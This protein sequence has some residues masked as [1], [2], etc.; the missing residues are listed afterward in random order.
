MNNQNQDNQ[1]Y[2]GSPNYANSPNYPNNQ[3]YQNSPNYPN[4]QNVQNPEPASFEPAPAPVSEPSSATWN[5][6]A[7]K[8]KK[9]KKPLLIALI[10]VLVAALGV[11]G[12]FVYDKFLKGDKNNGQTLSSGHETTKASLEEKAP[13]ELSAI[14]LYPDREVSKSDL[15]SFASL[16][17][18]RLSLLG[19]TYEIQIDDKKI[20]LIIE[21]SLLGE[22]S[23]ERTHTM[24]LIISRGNINFGYNEYTTYDSATKD[25]ISSITITEF[26]RKEILSDY[27]VDLAEDRYEQFNSMDSDTLYGLEITLSSEGS[28]KIDKVLDNSYSD[29]K[30]TVSHDYLEENSYDT[31]SFFGS[32][33]LKDDDDTS[34]LYVISPGST[35]QKNAEV[36]KKILEQDEMEFG[37]VMQI[38]DEP[39]WET[40]GKN[41]GKNQVTSMSDD[42]IVVEY[43]PDDFTRSYNS[44][45][46]FAEFELLVKDRMDVLDIDYMFGTT[47]FDDKT[48]CLKV[49]PQDFAPDF[50]RLIFGERSI[51]VYSSFDQ[52]SSFSQP[53]VVEENGQLSI[54]VE[55]SYDLTR[56]MSEYNIPGNTVYLVANDVTIATADITQLQTVD[57]KSY[58]YFNTFLCFG[59][60]QVTSDDR[61]FLDLVV[62]IYDSYEYIAS[63][64]TFRFRNYDPNATEE[65]T[66]LGD[67]DWKYSTLTQE[68]E[69]I[70]E[71]LSSMG[72]DAQKMVDKRNMLIITIDLPVDENL[73]V[74]FTNTLKE[75]Y[76]ACNFD[77]GAYNEIYFVIKDETKESPANQFRFKA[78]KDLYDGKMTITDTVSGP[79]FSD[80][81]MDVYDLMNADPF[82]IERDI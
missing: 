68:D 5:A 50:F 58:L 70:F 54:R 7:E 24:E 4:N 12:Y 14:E 45:V 46:D 26:D 44:E 35:Y 62:S 29:P 3:N 25:N 23:M 39:I 47:G 43:S 17:E 30:L 40:E 81:W 53:E 11:G 37:L 8:S 73:P 76:A 6:P 1:N 18:E 79:K 67:I 51:S 69:R 74:N 80:Y 36:M 48:Y 82:F 32:A 56:I 22:T 61:N 66:A 60:K 63:E 65:N 78:Y 57:N 21:K 19:D 38:A 33:L 49:L 20:T 59:D 13:E 31:K 27:R 16:M 52:I 77:G 28:K 75:I 64:G 2:Q 42:A 10:I 15:E 9:S 72:Y 71:L 55:T 34:V 41:M